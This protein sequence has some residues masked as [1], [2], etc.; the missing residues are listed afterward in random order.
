MMVVV[1][2]LFVGGGLEFDY[3]GDFVGRWLGRGRLRVAVWLLVRE[4]SGEGI[5]HDERNH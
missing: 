4:R 2:S 5:Q 3:A 1:N